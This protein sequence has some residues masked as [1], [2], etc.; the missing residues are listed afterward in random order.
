MPT[1]NQLLNGIR[2][3]RKKKVK[4]PALRGCPQKKGICLR[5]YVTTPKKPN[6]AMRKVARVKLNTRVAIL[7]Y[8]PGETHRLQRYST[9]LIRGGRVP[10]LPGVRYRILRGLLDSEGLIFRT[11]R[12]SLYGTKRAYKRPKIRNRIF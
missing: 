5:V 4:S 12:R 6:S 9:V 11:R 2:T 10:D 3:K 8:I 1:Y 7:T